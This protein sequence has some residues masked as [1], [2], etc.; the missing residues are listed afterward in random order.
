MLCVVIHKFILTQKG[1]LGKMWE[2][3]EEEIDRRIKAM[4][5]KLCNECGEVGH[6]QMEFR[7]YMLC[8]YCCMYR[9]ASPEYIAENNKIARRLKGKDV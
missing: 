7:D 4:P 2:P 1:L 8:N 5:R 3:D 6:I 9:Y